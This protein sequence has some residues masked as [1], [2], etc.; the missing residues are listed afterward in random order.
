MAKFFFANT[1]HP[2]LFSLEGDKSNVSVV[3]GDL[4]CAKIPSECTAYVYLPND[5]L[6]NFYVSF[7][8][9]PIPI[10]ESRTRTGKTATVRLTTDGGNKYHTDIEMR[11]HIFLETDYKASGEQ[12]RFLRLY[13]IT[14]SYRM[15]NMGNGNGN[16]ENGWNAFL[17]GEEGIYSYVVNTYTKL[18]ALLKD[19]YN[20][21]CIHFTA[22]S[23]GTATTRTTDTI[24]SVG[25]ASEETSE[26]GMP[27]RLG[28]YGCY[29]R[30][31]II[32]QDP[33]T[34][35]DSIKEVPVTSIEGAEWYNSGGKAYTER[36]NS[37]ATVHLD[38]GALVNAMSSLD[39]R[40]FAFAGVT[41]RQGDMITALEVR[42]GN[43]SHQNNLDTGEHAY[44]S[45]W[46]VVDG[47]MPNTL[48]M[49]TR[50]VTT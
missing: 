8:Y 26:V 24:T 41:N 43:E 12:Y 47:Y 29:V 33:I 40:K 38:Q 16:T 5:R 48:T 6:T 21:F 22:S 19:G 4:K 31:V 15:Y 39:A 30:N 50:R 45:A 18:G 35:S 20:K 25:R 28:I 7:E 42:R 46:D 44:G 2:E 9:M 32:S 34:F 27:M 23:S 17:A 3:D 11:S 49:T 37:S 36:V 13:D 1:W 10:Y 14:Q